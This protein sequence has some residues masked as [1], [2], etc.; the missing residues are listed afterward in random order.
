M[1]DIPTI[2][3]LRE[4]RRRLAEQ[5]GLDVQRYAALLQQAA[6]RQPGT[7]VSTPL[8]PQPM[9]PFG[10]STDLEHEHAGA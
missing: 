10:Q 1:I 4:A 3:E 9:S 7:Y 8:L 2:D 6:A 5:S